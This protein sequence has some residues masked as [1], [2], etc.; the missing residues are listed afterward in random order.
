MATQALNYTQSES[1][2]VAEHFVPVRA[3]DVPEQLIGVSTWA[4]SARKLVSIHARHDGPVII[5][6]EPGTGKGF[7]ARLIHRAGRFQECPFVMLVAG[8][9]SERLANDVLLDLLSPSDTGLGAIGLPGGSTLYLEV[10]PDSEETFLS[11]AISYVDEY[12]RG[13]ASTDLKVRLLIGRATRHS[14]G[15]LSLDGSG[16]LDCETMRIPALRFRTDDI[17]PLAR[18][19][20][21]QYC[22]QTGKEMRQV[23]PDAMNALR[24]YDWPR[25]VSELKTLVQ[26]T[27]SQSKPPLVEASLLP[28]YM[29]AGCKTEGCVLPSDGID[30]AG[31]VERY[32]VSLIC[33][34]LQ[35]CKGR[36]N[37]AAQLLRLK[38]TTLFMKL[39]RYDIEP[40][41]F[42]GPTRLRPSSPLSMA[43][44][45]SEEAD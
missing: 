24:R 18:H 40:A 9:S 2:F 8:K 13:C 33:A 37:A 20:I 31:E 42:R 7:L 41:Q 26:R 4:Q 17:E 3:Y 12:N 6:G 14:T 35:Q 43:D 32:E 15:N 30:L 38:P 21:N 28:A 34:A 10:S 29:S 23:S 22:Q 25:N 27:V 45:R 39:K 1:R 11:D 5:E 36:Q 19:F 16:R 44:D